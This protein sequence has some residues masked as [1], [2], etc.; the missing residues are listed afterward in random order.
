MPESG[1]NVE[2]KICSFIGDTFYLYFNVLN[3]A[4]LFPKPR[5]N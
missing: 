3:V 5:L 4:E 1:W 2:C